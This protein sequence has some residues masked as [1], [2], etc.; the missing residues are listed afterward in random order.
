[1][2]EFSNLRTFVAV[3]RSGSFA[4]AARQMNV[5]PAMVGRR[6]QDLEAR[7]RLKLIERTT[8]TQR[9][10]PAGQEFL[11][12]AEAALAA[13]DALDDVSSE[14]A[15]SGRLRISAPTTL[16]STRLPSIVADFAAAHPEVIVEMSLSDRWVDL[17][18][19]GFD[20]AV[21]VGNLASSS[22]IAR[23]IGTYR[24][25]CCASPDFLAREGKPR[26]PADLQDRRCIL[27]M[28]LAPRNRW[29]FR[30]AEGTEIAVEV[31][32]N[33]EI[34]NDVAMRSVALEGSG[35]VYVPRDLVQ[36]DLKSGQLVELLP[37]WQLRTLPIHVVYPSRH[38]LPRRV[39]AF[40]EA[41][42]LGFKR[43]SRH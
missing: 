28:N 22:L 43:R 16:G 29:S 33:I 35:I 30:D 27:N 32:G 4:A 34:D 6:I 26:K 19:E 23:P 25:V 40:I 13:A 39:A 37:A 20:M 3:V 9:L 15:L 5:S 24:F 14:G 36:A 2:T 42:L 7:Y 11:A 10:T 8:R 41:A 12:R 1:M 17:I 18:A 38:L 21:R 31:S